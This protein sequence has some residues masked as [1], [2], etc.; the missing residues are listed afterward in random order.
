LPAGVR[1]E[2]AK[3]TAGLRGE[4]KRRASGHR[5]TEDFIRYLRDGDVILC[6]IG[7][8]TFNEQ[9]GRYGPIG[10]SV[11]PASARRE[12]REFALRNQTRASLARVIERELA[13]G[14]IFSPSPSMDQRR[15][16]SSS[17]SEGGY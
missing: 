7:S 6:D 13:T 1:S 9:T 3:R 10:K 11:L 12:Q 5:G 14:A 2:Y 16:L 4:A 8:V 17:E 15:L